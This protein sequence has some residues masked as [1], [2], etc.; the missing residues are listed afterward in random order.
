MSFESI[1]AFTS[2]EVTLEIIFK[3]YLKTEYS[4]AILSLLKSDW[5][6]QCY[7]RH[8]EQL[9]CSSLLSLFNQRY[10][11]CL[12]GMC[13]SRGM[14]RVG[15]TFEMEEAWTTKSYVCV[16]ERERE[17]ERGGMDD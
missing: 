17:R 3:I 12:T 16:C 8:V 15:L 6:P 11:K 2:V 9:N 4:R 7:R 13:A 5:L 1:E 10:G 14:C